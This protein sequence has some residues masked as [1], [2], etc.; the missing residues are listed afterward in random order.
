LGIKT[1]IFM[2]TGDIEESSKRLCMAAGA[3]KYIN[4]PFDFSCLMSAIKSLNQ[5]E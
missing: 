5:E 2:L 4:K 1:P 3:N